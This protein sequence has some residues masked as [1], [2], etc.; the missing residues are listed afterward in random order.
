MINTQCIL[1]I[2]V[3]SSYK[4]GITIPILWM[5]YRRPEETEQLFRDIEHLSRLQR[6]WAIS[7]FFL[8]AKAAS[9]GLLCKVSILFVGSCKLK[10]DELW[11]RLLHWFQVRIKGLDSMTFKVIFCLMSLRLKY[12]SSSPG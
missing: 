11:K 10:S 2:I 9:Q 1:A 4:I 7:K 6:Q 5:R 12:F 8:A 3:K